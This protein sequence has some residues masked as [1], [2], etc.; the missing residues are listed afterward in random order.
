MLIFGSAFD[1]PLIGA[2][3][4]LSL[5]FMPITMVISGIIFGLV[6]VAIMHVFAKLLGGKGTFTEFFYLDA[7]YTA[8]ILIITGLLNLIPFLG[9]IAAFLVSLYSFYLLTLV[10]K[11]AHQLST[12]KAVAVWLVPIIIFVVLA[13]LL[14]VALIGAAGAAILKGLAASGSRPPY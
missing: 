8:P 12:G 6:I 2:F 5:V 1:N 11:E 10:I 4:A 9:G 14:M 13:V 3:S 7:I